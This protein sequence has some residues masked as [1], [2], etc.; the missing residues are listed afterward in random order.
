MRDLGWMALC[1][2]QEHSGLHSVTLCSTSGTSNQDPNALGPSPI[3][4]WFSQYPF[5]LDPRSRRLNREQ[6]FLGV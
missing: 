5:V 1:L 4:T 3:R 2:N 6:I